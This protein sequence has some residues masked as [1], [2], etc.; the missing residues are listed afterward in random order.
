M[1]ENI[2]KTIRREEIKLK[3]LTDLLLE[4]IITSEDFKTKKL[5]MAESIE[6]LRCERDKIDTR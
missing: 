1:Q 5:S 2:D 6:R 3:K 4:D